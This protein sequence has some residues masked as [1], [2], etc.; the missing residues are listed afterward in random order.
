MVRVK[1]M[2]TEINSMFQENVLIRKLMQS[3]IQHF[4]EL[5]LCV[6]LSIC[7]QMV[8][9]NNCPFPFCLCDTRSRL[10]LERDCCLR[11]TPRPRSRTRTSTSG[12][13]RRI[14]PAGR[15]TAP[16]PRSPASSWSS[17]NSATSPTTRDIRCVCVCEC[18]CRVHVLVFN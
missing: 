2:Q 14:L 12:L 7:K 8:V 10:T 1:V 11:S 17:G 13:E 16:W 3:F 5:L 9:V 15:Q 4:G 18:E 6:K